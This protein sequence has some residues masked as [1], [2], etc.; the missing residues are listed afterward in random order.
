MVGWKFRHLIG[1]YDVQNILAAIW[2]HDLIEDARQTYN[3][4][5]T[6]TNEFVA[7]IV[8]AVTNEKGKNRK[9][10]QNKKY[11]NGIRETPGATFVKLCDRISNIE[12]SVNTK[13]RMLEVYRKESNEFN[14]KLYNEA[15]SEMFAYMDE[16]LKEKE[17]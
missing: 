13:S 4:V 14:E 16:L 15:Y 17:N 11:Y 7:E 12:N 6:N 5:K 2:C 1:E 10:R 3:D 8:Y 9:E